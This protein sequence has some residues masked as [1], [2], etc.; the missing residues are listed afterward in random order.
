MLVGEQLGETMKTVGKPFVGPAAAG[1][2]IGR[3]PRPAS[4]RK[5]TF[6]TM[7]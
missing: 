1:A 7:L 3:W 4:N 6:L 5:D 2:P